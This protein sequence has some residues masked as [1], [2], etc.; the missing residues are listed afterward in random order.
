MIIVNARN[1]NQALIHG[2]HLLADLGEERPSRNGPAL[3][4]PEP[5]TTVYREPTERV[6]F[7]PERDANPFFHFYESLWMLHGQRDVASVAQYAKNIKS[8]SDDGV[9]FHG[10]YGF[11]WRYHFG[12]DQLKTVIELLKKN[13][14]DRRCVIQMWDAV[15]DLG[16][17]G[18]DFPCNTQIFFA[19]QSDGSLDMT[20]SNRSND[21]IWGAYGANAVHFSMLHEFVAGA[22]GRAVGVYRQMS[23]N[24][25][26]YVGEFEKRNSL[27]ERDTGYDPYQ[28]KEVSPFAIVNTPYEEW[29]QDL[30]MFLDEG[31]TIGLRDPF[32][33][34]VA[35][36]ILMSH[37]HYRE[38]RGPARYQGSLEIIEQCKASDWQ[39]AC[40]EWILRRESNFRKA[41]DDGPSE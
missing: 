17:E 15:F 30:G 2:M 27:L 28:M 23:N 40:R 24:F 39:R 25:H 12:I 10:A 6:V 36:P 3:V 29:L 31:V 38:N 4:A 14:D 19:V 21:M 18:K 35:T 8:Y 26:A 11:R 5:V 13:P 32:F 37:R 1:V 16:Q 7:W 33:R 20:V 22:L 9:T 34:K 41:D